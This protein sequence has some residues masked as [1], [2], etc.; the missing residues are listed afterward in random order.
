LGEADLVGIELEARGPARLWGQWLGLAETSASNT[1][2]AKPAPAGPATT[3][4]EFRA[5]FSHYWSRL[6][7]LSGPY[8]H[9]PGQPAW[10]LKLGFDARPAKSKFRYGASLGF[11]KAQRYQAEPQTWVQADDDLSLEAYGLYSF[12]RSERLRLTVQDLARWSSESLNQRVFDEGER[13]ETN[14]SPGR[15]RVSA[16]YEISF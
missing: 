12:S 8:N 7:S 15:L 13:L 10:E 11:V 5:S 14:H 4:L 2:N 3:G 16:R 6:N 1:D 9:L